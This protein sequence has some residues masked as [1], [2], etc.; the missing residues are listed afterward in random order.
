MGGPRA[1]RLNLL[2]TLG[3]DVSSARSGM[4]RTRYLPDLAFLDPSVALA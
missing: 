1:C 2:P 4:F 3:G